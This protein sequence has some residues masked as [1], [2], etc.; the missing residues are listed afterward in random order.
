M[1]PFVE[2]KLN[3]HLDAG[4]E[5]CRIVDMARVS[6]EMLVPEKEVGDV[7]S[8]N[9]ITMKA[10]SLPSLNLQGRV[11]FI[12]PVAQTVNG[13]RSTDGCRTQ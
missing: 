10:R 9:P 5:L 13:Q 12:A 8:G 1:T 2:R 7:R 11:D 6:V 3:Q 4:D